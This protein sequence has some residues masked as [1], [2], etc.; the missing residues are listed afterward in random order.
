MTVK[1]LRVSQLDDPEHH[2]V[3][4]EER[5]TVI[6]ETNSARVLLVVFTMRYN[7]IRVVMAFEA[8]GRMRE[9][10]LSTKGR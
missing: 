6:G 2:V 9:A 10:Y 8:S 4:G 5:W 1:L 3:N 7:L